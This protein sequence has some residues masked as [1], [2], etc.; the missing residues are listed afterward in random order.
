MPLALNKGERTRIFSM[1]EDVAADDGPA[2]S[3]VTL[4]DG[5][6][7]KVYKVG[8]LIRVDMQPMRQS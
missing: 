2:K 5:T 8:T 6:T 3:E 4:A 7:L 1:I